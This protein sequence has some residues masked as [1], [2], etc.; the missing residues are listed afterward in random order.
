MS[1]TVCLERVHRERAAR[2]DEFWASVRSL[3]RIY[4]YVGQYQLEAASTLRQIETP[5]YVA[6]VGKPR[7]YETDKEV[8]VVMTLLL[9]HAS[10]DFSVDT[11]TRF[12]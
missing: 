12:Y 2:T 10:S 8:V 3:I 1:A 6:V 5:T 4:V 7:S 11:A 9:D